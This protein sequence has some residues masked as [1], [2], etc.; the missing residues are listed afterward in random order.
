MT[1]AKKA[2]AKRPPSAAPAPKIPELEPIEPA[3]TRVAIDIEIFYER[4]ASDDNQPLE[5]VADDLQ[6]AVIA[7]VNNDSLG[8]IRGT[9]RA[10]V[11]RSAEGPA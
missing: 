10:F 9:F 2:A 6:L 7:A 11:I 4:L 1:S 8:A 5:D 3:R